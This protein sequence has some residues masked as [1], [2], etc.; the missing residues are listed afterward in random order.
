MELY[1]PTTRQGKTQTFNKYRAI[2]N[3]LKNM[4]S[5]VC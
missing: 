2:T 3:I 4:V 1:T 5:V